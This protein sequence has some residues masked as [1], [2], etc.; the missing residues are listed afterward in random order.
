MGIGHCMADESVFCLGSSALTHGEPG[1]SA[2]AR[3]SRAI[4]RAKRRSLSFRAT[5]VSRGIAPVLTDGPLPARIAIPRRRAA[6]RYT[7]ALYACP[8]CANARASSACNSVRVMY[9][10]DASIGPWSAS[11]TSG[12]ASAARCRS[13]SS[14]ARSAFS[15]VKPSDNE[16]ND[17]RSVRSALSGSP[18]AHQRRPRR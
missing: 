5:E 13:I 9:A 16:V 11:L 1:V 7:A 12:I 18:R 15:L 17:A 4:Q 2:R 6:V 10:F 8:A 14:A 3:R